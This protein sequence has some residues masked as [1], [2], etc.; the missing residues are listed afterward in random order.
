MHHEE[1][2]ENEFFFHHDVEGWSRIFLTHISAFIFLT[3]Y[4]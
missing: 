1:Q 2:I 3:H 4:D